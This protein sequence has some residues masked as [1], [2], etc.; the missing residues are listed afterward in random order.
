[1]RIYAIIFFMFASQEPGVWRVIFEN[2]KC[3][4][5]VNTHRSRSRPL[6][7][8]VTVG[9]KGKHGKKNVAAVLS[10]GLFEDNLP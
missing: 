4:L 7:T 2:V 3:C 10:M 6:Y 9:F 5:C 1:M 8:W